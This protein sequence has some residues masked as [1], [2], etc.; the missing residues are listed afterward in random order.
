MSILNRESTATHYIKE[1]LWYPVSLQIAK[2]HLRIEQD[3]IEDDNYIRTLIKTATIEAENIIGMSIAYTKNTVQ[4]FDFYSDRVSIPEGNFQTLVSII[5]DVSTNVGYSIINK[6]KGRF[7]IE[8]DT[9]YDSDP[10]TVT[11][12]SGYP[13]NT[14]NQGELEL[15]KQY[16]LVRIADMF[17]PER[18]QWSYG[19]LKSQNSAESLLNGFLGNY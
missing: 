8:L 19:A 1:K 16:I 6:S 17:E 5:N 11:F 7:V 9:A 2:E 10:L 13:E 15:L 18:S 14:E 12:Y 3:D 4:F